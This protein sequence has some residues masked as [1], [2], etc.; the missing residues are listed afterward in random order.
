MTS[1]RKTIVYIDGFNLY[2]GAVSNT[3]YKWLNPVDLCSKILTRNRIVKIK[4][5][6]AKVTSR[7][8]DPDQGIRQET[9]LRALRTIPNLEIFYGH[10]L[11][12]DVW[13]KLSNPP[14]KGPE[15]VQV[16]KTEEKG[17]DVNL[18]SHL[19]NDAHNDAFDVAVI[20]T[21]DSDLVEPIRIVRNE[22]GLTVGVINPHEKPAYALVSAATFIRKIRPNLLKTCQFP[23]TLTDE[24]GTFSKPP[25][26]NI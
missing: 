25:L 10:F 18:A 24:K 8:K 4:Y 12:H 19:I 22:I 9:Y 20:I 17:S 26:W 2:Y 23:E 6:T 15:F 16:V 3:P 1:N 11:S 5:F 14:S 21:N 13:M 7:A